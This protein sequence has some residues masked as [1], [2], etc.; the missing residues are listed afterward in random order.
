MP[1]CHTFPINPLPN[2]NL[3]LV[4]E[5]SLGL[6]DVCFTVKDLK[7]SYEFYKKL[8]LEIWTGVKNGEL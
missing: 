5:S 7:S 1:L 3:N 6:A 2:T 8:E 4:D